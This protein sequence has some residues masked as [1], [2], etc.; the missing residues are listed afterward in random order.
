MTLGVPRI[1]GQKEIH[2]WEKCGNEFKDLDFVD[3]FFIVYSYDKPAG[4]T[5]N[6]PGSLVWL[7]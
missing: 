6:K 3:V 2:G 7:L 1:D 5:M 4:T